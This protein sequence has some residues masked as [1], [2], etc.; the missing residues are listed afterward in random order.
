VPV[1]VLYGGWEPVARIV[2]VAVLGY[3]ALVLLLR[4]TGKRTLSRMNQ[5]DFVITVALGATFGSSL[6]SSP[7]ALAET[8]TAFAVLIGLQ[9]LVA[10][11]QSRHARF[12]QLVTATPRLLAHRGQLLHSA[13]MDERV[14]QEEVD[15]AVRLHGLGSLQEAEAVVLETDGRMS[16]VPAQSAG[17]ASALRY[18]RRDDQSD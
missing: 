13:L 14:T 5:F 4:V 16:V 3:L 1:H 9:L 17:D 12:S 7:V 10:R 8:V 2:L 18:V 15:A 6:T 11:L